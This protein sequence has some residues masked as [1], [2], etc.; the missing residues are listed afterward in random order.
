M[1]LP[2]VKES[3]YFFNSIL[4]EKT[5]ELK[6]QPA[7]KIAV[8][9]FLLTA[10]C[11]FVP[12]GYFYFSCCETDSTFIW[13]GGFYLALGLIYLVRKYTQKMSLLKT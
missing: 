13:F 4:E 6:A 3:G 11:Y 8:P 10:L 5:F 2:S 1:V 7:H 9:L 12:I